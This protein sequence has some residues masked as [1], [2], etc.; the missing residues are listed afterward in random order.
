M[1]KVFFSFLT[2][3]MLA[4]II[5]ST[6]PTMV[7]EAADMSGTYY[8]K[9][10]GAALYVD[11]VSNTIGS[12]ATVE[13]LDPYSSQK[14]TVTSSGSGYLIQYGTSNQYLTV[15]NSSSALGA[16]V[17]LE[18]LTSGSSGQIWTFVSYNGGYRIIPNCASSYVLGTVTGATS[19]STGAQLK[20]ISFRPDTYNYDLW[21]MKKVN[22]TVSLDVDKDSY[23]VTR[24][25]ST[26]A[27]NRIDHCLDMLKLRMLLAANI[28]VVAGSTFDT[29]NLH[30]RPNV[31]CTGKNTVSSLCTCGTC[32][33]STA[34]TT[35]MYH[36]TNLYNNFY[37]LTATSGKV[38]AVF[39]GHEMC[40][41]L[42]TTHVNS[43]SAA[44]IF[45]LA[46]TDRDLVLIKDFKTETDHETMIFVRAILELYGLTDHGTGSDGY[47]DD[48]IFGLNANTS[49]VRM[50]CI[51]CSGCIA[52]LKANADEYD[53]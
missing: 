40:H 10:L 38:R 19:I 16:S 33:D 21:D 29:V 23:Y 17:V 9:N 4:V 22:Y 47:G 25:G 46:R 7:A 51:L 45:N 11:A 18:P 44:G 15:K 39:T 41:A 12:A 6:P 35:K 37:R 50:D 2:F 28:E 49:D 34:L 14:W 53:H 31:T 36:H 24:Y 8:I 52:D 20:T 3:M 1:K 42:N 43:T 26:A 32:E 48:C 30:A 27:T 13:V 5:F